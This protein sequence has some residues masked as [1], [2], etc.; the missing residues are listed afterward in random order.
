MLT[1][2]FWDEYFISLF[3]IEKKKNYFPIGKQPW[4]PQ[5]S[6]MQELKTEF[7][8]KIK[9]LKNT[10]N[11]YWYLSCLFDL[12]DSIFWKKK[13][14]LVQLFIILGRLSL[15][16]ASHNFDRMCFFDSST[17]FCGKTIEWP[18][19]PFWW[20]NLDFLT[21]GWSYV[22][23]RHV[24]HCICSLSSSA[25]NC[26]NKISVHWNRSS[27][28]WPFI[29]QSRLLN[30]LNAFKPFINCSHSINTKLSSQQTIW[31]PRFTSLKM[32][33]SWFS[34]HI[35]NMEGKSF[36]QR[37]TCQLKMSEFQ[38]PGQFFAL[39]FLSPTY[40]KFADECDWNSKIWFLKYVRNLFFFSKKNRE[41]GQICSRMCKNWY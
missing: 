12:R 36:T 40:S 14:L 26:L 37:F 30:G 24:S 8:S 28:C 1:K 16:P 19:H 33:V 2:I 22:K 29:L 3:W 6:K 38:M 20:E 39:I 4:G 35:H 7:L 13:F 25:A 21:A 17:T 41:R 15:K 32:I 18:W 9:N 31:R 27:I 10:W 11:K 23:S 5:L 34:A